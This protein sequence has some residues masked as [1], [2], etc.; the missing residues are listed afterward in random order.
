MKKM[1]VLLNHKRFRLLTEYHSFLLKGHTKLAE[2]TR[3]DLGF[4]LLT[5]YH[6]FL[7]LIVFHIVFIYRVS[8]SL[9]SI[10]HSYYKKLE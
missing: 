2:T 1:L 9:R 10:I 4:R 7:F 8:V 3:D 6:S 5:E